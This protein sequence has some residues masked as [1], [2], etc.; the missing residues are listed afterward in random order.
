M[1]KRQVLL[2]KSKDLLER[3]SR[4]CVPSWEIFR[5]AFDKLLTI[6]EAKKAG[7]PCPNTW[8]VSDLS[9]LRRISKE[10]TYPAVIKPRRKIVWHDD[11]AIMVKV[12]RKNYVHSINEL[13]YRYELIIRQYPVLKEQKMLPLVQEYIEGIGLGFEALISQKGKLLTFFMHRRL[14]EYPVTGGA[15]TLRESIY[16]KELFEY[17]IRFLKAIGW[18]GV[19]MVEFKKKDKPCLMEINGRFWGSL[20]LAINAGV[21]FPYLCTLM[22]LGMEK[23][24]YKYKLGFRQKWGLPGEILWLYGKMYENITKKASITQLFCNI[25][26]FAKSFIMTRDDV[27]SLRDLRPF[28]GSLLTTIE[29][30]Y[31]VIKGRRTVEGERIL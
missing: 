17:G 15:S 20:P 16:D 8:V 11:K 5:K 9:D 18:N 26:E 6:V 29:Y 12:T 31:D 3:Y 4:V 22:L 23:R 24:N 25:Y 28:V 13:I 7:I 19:A 14:H 30:A 21:D 27:L 2:S 1:Y 10:I